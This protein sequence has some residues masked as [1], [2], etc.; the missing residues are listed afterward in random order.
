[1]A[2]L[3]VDEP[4]AE[5]AAVVKD[6]SGR[7]VMSLVTAH[8]VVDDCTAAVNHLHG[9]ENDAAGRQRAARVVVV[10]LVVGDQRV[11][12]TREYDAAP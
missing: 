6:V 12:R 11:D 8:R 3:V 1:M 5:P 10:H 7:V 4:V 2:A 9:Q